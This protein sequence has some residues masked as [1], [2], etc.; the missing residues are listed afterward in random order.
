MT[1]EE[2]KMSNVR[3]LPGQMAPIPARRAGPEKKGAG[4]ARGLGLSSTTNGNNDHERP[5]L[6]GLLLVGG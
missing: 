2:R 6:F 1:D 3:A 5:G 4:V